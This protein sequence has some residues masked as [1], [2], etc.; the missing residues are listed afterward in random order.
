MLDT[1]KH[2]EQDPSMVLTSGCTVFFCS[3]CQLTCC[4]HLRFYQTMGNLCLSFHAVAK[5][6]VPLM[7]SDFRSISITPGR[8]LSRPWVHCRHWLYLS[9]TPF[10]PSLSRF[11]R[12]ICFSTNWLNGCSDCP[13]PPHSNSYVIAY[14]LD[15]SAF[16]IVWH[17]A[18][19]DCS[20][21]LL[22]FATG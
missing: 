16:D 3:N 10:C 17:S 2:T 4:C 19:L 1:L 12:S 7:P 5:V 8:R 21:S 6:S 20:P 14:A 11:R 9:F 13:P 22:T 15:F 18:L